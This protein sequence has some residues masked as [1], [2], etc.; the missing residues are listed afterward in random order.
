M[1]NIDILEGLCYVCVSYV[2]FHIVIITLFAKSSEID[3]KTSTEFLF[4]LNLLSNSS[5]THQCYDI[6][7][8]FY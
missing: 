1:K 8:V 2:N 6:L 5:K 4:Q 3:V 7:I